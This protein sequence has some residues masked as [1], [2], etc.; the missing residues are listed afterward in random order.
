M[1]EIVEIHGNI[2]VQ[3]Y[4]P[5]YPEIKKV[6]NV[7]SLYL[8]QKEAENLYNDIKQKAVNRDDIEKTR[9]QT[10]A[11]L[12]TKQKLSGK[13]LDILTKMNNLFNLINANFVN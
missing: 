10:L 3:N 9:Q 1:V 4:S 2:A 5:Q 6:L 13:K 12:K 7:L 11:D 8:K